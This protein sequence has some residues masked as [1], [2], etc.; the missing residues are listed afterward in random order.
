MVAP[1]PSADSALDFP[2]AVESMDCLMEITREVRNIRSTY[3]ISPGARVPLVVKTANEHD[4]AILAA[5]REYLVSLARLS[6]FEFG[7]AVAKPEF[8]AAAI[9][10]GFEVY[11]PLADVIDLDAERRR[12]QKE[13]AKAEA[14]LARIGTK[15]ENADFIRKAPAE[16]VSRERAAQADLA[17][18]RA[19]LAA[20]LEHIETHLKK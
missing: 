5:G 13:L 20:S 1:W 9:V 15:L 11:V 7:G 4:D 3:D 19:K 10:R 14:A 12:L 17:V 16:V 2:Q 8:A 6:R 18:Q